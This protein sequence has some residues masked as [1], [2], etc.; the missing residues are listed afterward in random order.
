[1]A[2]PLFVQAYEMIP[3]N[4]ESFSNCAFEFAGS[5]NV[6]DYESCKLEEL[7]FEQDT[8]SHNGFFALICPHSRF[9]LKKSL[10]SNYENHKSVQ[11]YV[12]QN[13]SS[14][15]CSKLVQP[16]A[17]ISYLGQ[18]EP[19]YHSIFLHVNGKTFS[20]IIDEM[21]QHGLNHRRLNKLYKSIGLTLGA[22]HN[23]GIVDHNND[24]TSLKSHLVHGDLHSSNIIIQPDDTV[25]FVDIDNLSI[26][27]NSPQHLIN[28]IHTVTL[29]VLPTPMLLVDNQDLSNWINYIPNFITS[30]I[31]GYC[32]SMTK[33]E[34]K[35]CDSQIRSYMVTLL[36]F[37]NQS[38]STERILN[39]KILN[40]KVK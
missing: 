30:F 40:K 16:I 21:H 26:S 24:F 17:E 10:E 36:M 22:L 1:M 4:L 7:D 37:L 31:D 39:E 13:C 2:L 11:D 9:F 38:F 15:S 34:S 23:S 29:Q 3:C 35:Q 14:E 32:S 8:V 28:D 12:L 18:S 25:F 20:A 6:E 19:V 5:Y 27:V 33:I